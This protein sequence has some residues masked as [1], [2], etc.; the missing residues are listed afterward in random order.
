MFNVLKQTVPERVSK[1]YNHPPAGM[2]RETPAC[3]GGRAARGAASGPHERS[4][5][6]TRAVWQCIA[7]ACARMGT[8][9]I[10]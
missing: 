6:A 8:L 10:K 9:Y 7:T 3:P 1:P 4:Y 2:P 5:A